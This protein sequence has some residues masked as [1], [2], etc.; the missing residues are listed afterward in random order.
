[1]KLARP[2]QDVVDILANKGV[3]VRQEIGGRH[4]KLF[5]N[6]RL[7]GI[8]PKAEAKKA[9][10]GRGALNVAAQLKRTARE[11]GVDI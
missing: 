1:V 5:I 2:V 10:K 8:H 3:T 9:E 7:A 4:I 6:N 11:M